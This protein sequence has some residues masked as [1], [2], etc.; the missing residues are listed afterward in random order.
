MFLELKLPSF[1][2]VIYNAKLTIC[3][4]SHS[5]GGKSG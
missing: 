2:T 1:N 5:V 4:S 3:A